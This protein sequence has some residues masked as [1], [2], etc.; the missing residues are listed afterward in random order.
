[1]FRYENA[2]E[3]FENPRVGGSTPS[4]GTTLKIAPQKIAVSG[5]VLSHRAEPIVA[6]G[7]ICSWYEQVHGVAGKLPPVRL[8]RIGLSH[9]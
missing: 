4:L 2:G 6:V 5:P 1:M 9:L 3:R 8:S 7:K